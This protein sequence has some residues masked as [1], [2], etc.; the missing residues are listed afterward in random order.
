MPKDDWYLVTN[1]GAVLFY[2]ALHPGC[3]TDEVTQVMPVS[4]QRVMRILS[5]LSQEGMVRVRRDEHRSYYTA[6]SSVRLR[7]PKLT[8]YHL[9]LPQGDGTSGIGRPQGVIAPE[10]RSILDL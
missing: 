9:T 8:E 1:H 10:L 2:V 6:N 4:R 3:T 7:H 5:D